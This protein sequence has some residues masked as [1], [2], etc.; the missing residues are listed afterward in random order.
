MIMTDLYENT[1]GPKHK[2]VLYH[3]ILI[4]LDPKNPHRYID[5]TLGA[6]GHAWG[7]LNASSP[8]GELFGLD[9]D[10]TAIAL[11]KEQLSDFKKRINIVQG[12][13]TTLL[14]QLER[15]GWDKV[16]GIVLDLGV[17]S[18]QIDTPSRGFSFLKDGDLDMRFSPAFENTAADIVNTYKE[19][20]LAKIFWQ[21]GEERKSR[22]LAKAII[23]ERPFYRSLE[24]SD[25][26]KKIIGK[27]QYKIHPATRVFQA[28]R[29]EVNKEL[30]AL[31]RVLPQTINALS[32]GGRVAIIS[33]HSLEDRLVKQFFKLESKDCICPSGQPICNCGHK[34]KIKEVNRKPIRPTEKEI[35]ANPRARS[36]RLRIAQK[37]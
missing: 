13:Y 16:Q 34:A 18:M 14:E 23:K 6:G 21:Y 36:A 35:E 24:L 5:A 37:L 4:G 26:I 9:V 22:V 7:I 11:A 19:E 33:F 10:P 8:K 17:S 12:S 20:D 25:F 2:P 27:Q 32:S 30:E 1:K 28:L 3:E 15:I 31:N 29:I